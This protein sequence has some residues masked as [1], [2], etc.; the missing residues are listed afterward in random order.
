MDP[1]DLPHVADDSLDVEDDELTTLL[2]D[3][4]F[5][6]RVVTSDR[7]IDWNVARAINRIGLSREESAMTFLQLH[8]HCITEFRDTS[9]PPMPLSPLPPNLHNLWQSFFNSD[10]HRNNELEPKMAG[11]SVLKQMLVQQ[12]DPTGT[13]PIWICGVPDSSWHHGICGR[14]SRRWDRGITHIRGVH[15]NHRPYPCDGGCG[16]LAW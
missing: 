4:T 5:I 1:H 14:V 10:W 6:E 13:E 7:F 2:A 9:T 16:V 11:Y 12:S 15:L 3:P 8:P